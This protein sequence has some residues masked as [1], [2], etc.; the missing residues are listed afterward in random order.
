MAHAGFYSDNAHRA[1]PFTDVPT[2]A[3]IPEA[4]VV[5]FGVVAGLRALYV[6]AVSRVWLYR[7]ARA[8]TTVTFE[9]RCDAPGC[10]GRALLFERDL[11]DPEYA[12]SFAVDDV[13]P[14]GVGSSSSSSAGA[15]DCVDDPVLEGFLVTGRMAALADFLAD[16]AE[17]TDPA[18]VQT[19][20]PA[21][22]QNLARTYVR[23][24]SLANQDR[25]KVDPPDGCPTSSAAG[26]EDRLRVNA[27]C[28]TGELK[29]K[30]GYN[31]S[32]RVT[33]QDNSITISGQV[34][35]GEGEACEEVPLYPGE[36]SPDGGLLLTGGPRCDEILKSVNGVGGRVVR[37]QAGGGV[38]VV[39]GESPHTLIVEADLHGMALCAPLIESSVGGSS[40][41]GG[42]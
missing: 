10:E 29:V 28:L 13:V 41:G 25:T 33:R 39:P 6:D 19:V 14:G 23:Q 24:V 34:G 21:L 16:G 30:E 12:T 22:V 9:F 18:A 38:R 27:T 4:A 15:D 26:P 17:W 35:A 7:V 1:Y 2:A 36:A 5:D 37:I 32:V 8:G 3:A 42:P 20:E 40:I 31:C 11:A